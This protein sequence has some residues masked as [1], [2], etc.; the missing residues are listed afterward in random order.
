MYDQNQSGEIATARR[1]I[2]AALAAG[3]LVTVWDGGDE[4]AL[5]RSGDFTAIY[6]AVGNTDED[7]LSFWRP[8]EAVANSVAVTERV[9]TILLVWGNDPDGV[10]LISD[11]TAN[12]AMEALCE[13]AQ[14]R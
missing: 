7:V 1:L 5:R 11:H 9:G 8:V 2:E 13:A 3:Y 10:E 4:P 12:D 14:R 6:D